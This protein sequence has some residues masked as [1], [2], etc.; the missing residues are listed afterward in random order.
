[1]K[2]NNI[3]PGYKLVLENGNVFVVME[4]KGT[5]I[6]FLE[7][8]NRSVTAL[9]D[10]CDENL[11]PRNGILQIVTVLNSLDIPIWE[12]TFTRTDIQPG[13]TMLNEDGTHYL[14]V[15]CG[16]VLRIMSTKYFLVGAKLDDIMNEDMS[17]FDSNYAKIIE[18]KDR[19]GKVV[20]FKK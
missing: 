3:L 7:G 11:C 16:N 15:E 8:S 6:A 2:T 14:V 10:L 17:P 4:Y 13:F 9:N 1:M 20:Y 5:K 12:R 18:V 19:E